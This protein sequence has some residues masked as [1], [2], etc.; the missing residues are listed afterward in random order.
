MARRINPRATGTKPACAG[1]FGQ[2]TTYTSG[3]LR[4]EALLFVSGEFIRRAGSLRQRYYFRPLQRANT[5][6][7]GSSHRRRKPPRSSD[8]TTP[9]TPHSQD[10]GSPSYRR[11]IPGSEAGLVQEAW[12]TVFVLLRPRPGRR[13]LALRAVHV[14]V[15]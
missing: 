1:C 3:S 4:R 14:M 11:R 5:A 13:R 8:T 7:N 15:Y 9:E 10:R 2:T 6:A 12:R